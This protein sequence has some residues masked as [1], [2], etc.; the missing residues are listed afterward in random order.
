MLNI[1]YMLNTRE[2]TEFLSK[3]LSGLSLLR[4]VRKVIQLYTYRRD[5]YGREV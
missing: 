2:R 5:L 3:R 1:L 4:L